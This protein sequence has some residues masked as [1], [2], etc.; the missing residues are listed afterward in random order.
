MIVMP[1]LDWG[2]YWVA[3]L[4]IAAVLILGVA[5][6]PPSRR[7]R[8]LVRAMAMCC[9][10]AALARP[11][12]GD[13]TANLASEE[14]DVVFVVDVSPS[15]GALDWD[16]DRERIVGIREDIAALA[17]HHAGARFAVVTFNASAAQIQPFM[18][19][20]SGLDHTLERLIPEDAYSTSGSSITAATGLL[21]DLL[22]RSADDYP[23]HE[24]IVYY[25]GDGEQTSS[26]GV[27]SFAD[28]ADLVSGGAVLGY[29]TEDG[30]RINRYD[31]GRPT[32]TYI[33]DR[34]GNPG[35]SKADPEALR[36]IASDL[37]VDLQMRD[38][39]IDVIPAEVTSARATVSDGEAI[40]VAYPLY[41]V[42]ALAVCLWLLIETWW[43]SAALR[44]LRRERQALVGED[45]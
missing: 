4:A 42:F 20:R 1:V 11:G 37:D 22:Q 2:W 17:D 12:I 19:D 38:A 10:F 35:I 24:R 14:L 16:G 3:A 21:H 7:W 39:E 13:R 26:R 18:R 45:E 41:W 28:T 15:V 6:A 23:E 44:D 30:A 32:G 5:T 43:V 33:R 40:R 9:L 29:G 31:E 8:W 27:R 25:F 34:Q 36:Q